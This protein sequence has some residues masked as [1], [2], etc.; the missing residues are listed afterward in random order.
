MAHAVLPGRGRMSAKNVD[1]HRL[2]RSWGAVLDGGL[3]SR[4]RSSLAAAKPATGSLCVGRRYPPTAPSGQLDLATESDRLVLVS[5]RAV[6]RLSVRVRCIWRS[7]LRR[8]CLRTTAHV[9]VLPKTLQKSHTTSMRA[10]ASGS[11]STSRSGRPGSVQARTY[12]TLQGQSAFGIPHRAG[13]TLHKMPLRA[14][15]TRRLKGRLHRG[16]SRVSGR[17]SAATLSALM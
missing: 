6:R 9:Q 14:E 13:Y 15:H 10:A 7:G 16:Q 5:V 3:A 1:P 12:T 2:E 8:G 17:S 4:G 11:A